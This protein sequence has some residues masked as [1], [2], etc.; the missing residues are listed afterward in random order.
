MSMEQATRKGAPVTWPGNAQEGFRCAEA[1]HHCSSITEGVGCQAREKDAETPASNARIWGFWRMA[2]CRI[3]QGR[4]PNR[5]TK[6]S[7]E[8][9]GA[10]FQPFPSSCRLFILA[11]VQVRVSYPNWVV[12][13]LDSGRQARKPLTLSKCHA[14]EKCRKRGKARYVYGC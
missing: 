2:G 5:T 3:W 9:P 11:R 4:T 1:P 7:Q 12:G 6:L 10:R 13:F 8:N 14:H